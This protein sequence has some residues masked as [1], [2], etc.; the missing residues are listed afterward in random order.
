MSARHFPLWCSAPNNMDG[1]SGS[2][3]LRG[4]ILTGD[5][6]YFHGVQPEEGPAL[7]VPIPTLGHLVLTRKRLDEMFEEAERVRSEGRS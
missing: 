2:A 6:A 3:E 5:D 4:T 1:L 7:L